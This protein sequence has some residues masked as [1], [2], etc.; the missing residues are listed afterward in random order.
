MDEQADCDQHYHSVGE[1][2]ALMIA[3]LNEFACRLKANE[4]SHGA[5]LGELHPDARPAHF[6]FLELEDVDV[7]RSQQEIRSGEPCYA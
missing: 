5:T 6:R 7:P 1:S 4:C 2:G 3:E